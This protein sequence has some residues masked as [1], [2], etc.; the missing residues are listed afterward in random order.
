MEMVKI[1]VQGKEFE[2][3]KNT[4]I[5]DFINSY[6]IQNPSPILGAIVNNESRSL[7][8][9]MDENAEIRF[10]D[11]DSSEGV[12]I[13]RRSLLFLFIKV[14]EEL[15]P[16]ANVVVGHSINQGVFCEIRNA[17]CGVNEVF[18]KQIE[19]RMRELV[20][21][22]IPFI[23]SKVTKEEAKKIYMSLQQ[24]DKIGV[25]DSLDMDMVT[26]NQLNGTQ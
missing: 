20:T 13:Y 12:S 3:E 22:K 21:E 9:K 16:G 5:I 4:R 17:D 23:K 7:R 1:K 26:I 24:P 10:I 6:G 15:C 18:R 19:D 14:C 25:L 8:H 11:Y 2:I